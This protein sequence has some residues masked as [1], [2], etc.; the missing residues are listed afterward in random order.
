M[1]DLVIIAI[2]SATSSALPGVLNYLQHRKVADDIKVVREETDHMMDALVEA[3]F[4]AGAQQ[5]KDKNK[6]P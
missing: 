2:I 6:T 4:V 5:E 3:A 1:S